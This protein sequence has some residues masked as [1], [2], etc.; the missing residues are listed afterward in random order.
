MV[1]QCHGGDR[2]MLGDSYPSVM[3]G[4]R[5]RPGK[6]DGEYYVFGYCDTFDQD[7][8]YT[9]VGFVSNMPNAFS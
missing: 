5:L 4:F 1:E 7:H 9:N 3:I 6:N 2:R 8:F